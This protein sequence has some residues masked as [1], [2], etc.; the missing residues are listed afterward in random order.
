M[1]ETR[2]AEGILAEEEK[3]APVR[4]SDID[5]K[6]DIKEEIDETKSEDEVFDPFIPFPETGIEEERILSVRAIVVGC[7][8]GG[9]VNASNVYLGMFAPTE[10]A[11]RARTVVKISIR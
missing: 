11:P 5:E 3:R 1:S 6:T 9:L 7:I 10:L 4:T 8:L 2:T